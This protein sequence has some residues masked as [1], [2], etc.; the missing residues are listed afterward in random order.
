MQHDRM[1]SLAATMD[2]T[3]DYDAAVQDPEFRKARDEELESLERNGT[4]RIVR[5]PKGKKLIK[6]GWLFRKKRDKTGAVTRHKA[7]SFAKGYSMYGVSF[8]DRYA[9]TVRMTTIRVAMAIARKRGMKCWQCDVNNAYLH[10]HLKEPVYMELPRGLDTVYDPNLYCCEVV[11]GIYGLPP[12]G[13]V[14]GDEAAK[15]LTSLGFE[16]SLS[17]P[18]LFF[19]G[20]LRSKTFQMVCLYV[21]DISCYSFEKPVE[22]FSTLKEKYGI[23][24]EGELDFMLGVEVVRDKKGSMALSQGAYVD[25]VLEKFRM[26]DCRGVKCPF[27]DNKLTKAE[28]EEDAD[29]EKYRSIVG[30]IA[31]LMVCTRP[32]LACSVTK[33]SRHLNAPK[34]SHMIAAKRV[35]RYIK[36]TR[37]VCLMMPDKNSEEGLEM[38]VD[39]DHAGCLDTRRSTSGCIITTGGCAVHHSGTNNCKVVHVYLQCD[40]N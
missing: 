1:F 35:L 37:D 34:S 22:L 15:T 13:K 39:A 20:D 32:D 18:C 17:D 31:C 40:Q 29:E 9:P 12:S 6:N 2:T 26:E 19:R 27:S 16:R 8:K 25:K 23:K 33:L 24:D 21:D 11:K 28:D 14:W 10:G 5:R 36:Q 4:W 3:N 30:S 38:Y 7:R